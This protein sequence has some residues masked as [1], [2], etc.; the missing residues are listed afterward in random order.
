MPLQFINEIVS[1][2]IHHFGITHYGFKFNFGEYKLLRFEIMS[3]Y[4]KN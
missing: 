2:V 4:L 3:F 1:F